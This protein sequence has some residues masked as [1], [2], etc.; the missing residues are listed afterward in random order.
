S[1]GARITP[2]DS[3]H[4][5]LYQ[6]LVGEDP[7][8]VEQL[9]I[10]A[11]GGPFRVAPVDLAEVTPEQALLHPN[12]AMGRKVTIDSATLFNKGLEVL[13]AHFLFDLPLSKVAVVVHPQSLVHGLVRYADGS[14]KAQVGPH[15]MRLP[16]QYAIEAPE[17]PRVPLPPLPLSGSWEFF[18]PDL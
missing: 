3:E 15:D 10:T 12:W 8:D 16:I 18:E 7:G 14:I 4:S 13:E 11:S 9:V 5:A 17:R 6:C 2:V 1:S